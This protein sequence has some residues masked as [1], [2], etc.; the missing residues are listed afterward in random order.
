MKFDELDEDEREEWRAAER[1]EN[2]DFAIDD[3]E[4]VFRHSALS[5][6]GYSEVVLLGVFRMRDGSF[7][8]ARASCDTTGWDCRSSGESQAFEALAE[9]ES[10]FPIDEQIDLGILSREEVK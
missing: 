7:V 5:R 10:W 2:T 3:I 8:A 1:H 4:E 6:E 9:A